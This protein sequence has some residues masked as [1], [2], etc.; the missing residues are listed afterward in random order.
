[1][2][3][4]S[5]SKKPLVH[6]EDGRPWYDTKKGIVESLKSLE[7]LTRLIGERHSAG[8][9]REER[10]NE[11]FILGRYELDTCGNCLKAGGIIP[12]EL[13][14]DIPDILTGDEFW[15][16]IR[17][18]NTDKDLMLSFSANGGDLPLPGLKCAHCDTPWEIQ[19]CHD[20]VVWHTTEVFPLTEFVGK[21]LHDVKVSYGQ[22]D[23]AV[24]MMQPDI[25][26][27]NDKYVD[28]SPKYPNPEYDWEKSIVKNERG[29]L[30]EKD[31]ITDDYVIQAGDEGFFNVWEFFH[32]ACN[33]AYL[34]QE[35]ER[36]FRNI[37][38]KAGFKDILMESLPNEYCSCDHCAPWFNVNTEFGTIKI[39]WRKRV[40]NIDWSA[41]AETLKACGQ[42]PEKNILSLFEDEG[43]TKG[44]AYIHAWGWEKA[45]EYL[46]RIYGL[47][48]AAA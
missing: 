18:H 32:H 47:L 31:G 39:G 43:V 40:I 22:R 38:E 24:Y 45:Q 21:T 11:F 8:Y 25:I 46:S 33:R 42:L 15:A 30:G 12:K 10:L 17:E 23:N 29:W 27:R 6:D 48:A 1:M 9:E 3:K 2:L 37:F 44:D 7:G 36:Q 34:H 19:D 16:Y 35:K 20:T 28:L 5:I 13:L 26:I 14:P 41:A 4:L